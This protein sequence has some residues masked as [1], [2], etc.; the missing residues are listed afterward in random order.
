VLHQTD[1]NRVARKAVR[2]DLFGIAE[3]SIDATSNEEWWFIT[4]AFVRDALFP[5]GTRV[6]LEST[7]KGQSPFFIARILPF[8]VEDGGGCCYGLQSV[9]ASG[10]ARRAHN[11]RRA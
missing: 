10:T 1:K 3:I 2:V 5:I 4:R 6:S 7:L 9:P 11:E 8:S